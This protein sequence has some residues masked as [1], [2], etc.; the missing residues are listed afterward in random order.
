MRAPVIEAGRP[1]DLLVRGGTVVRAAGGR[2]ARMWRS[3]AAGSPPSTRRIPAMRPPRP[4]DATGLLVLPGVI[5]V[6][7][8]AAI[9][10]D[11]EPDRFFQDTVA[12]AFGGT[13][14]LLAFNNP[15]TGI[16]D[17]ARSDRCAPASR[18]G[19]RR[20]AARCRDRRRAVGGHHRAAGATRSRTL[21]ALVDDGRGVPSSASWSTTSAWTR[22]R[23]RRAAAGRS[24]RPAACSRSTARTGR[25]LDAGIAA[26]LAAGE[27]G[28]RG[29]A[30]SRPP[31][32][33]G[34]R[35][36]AG[37]SRIAR[38]VGAPVY[39]VHVSCR[40]R[41]RGDRAGPP[42]GP[43]RSSARR[44]PHYLALDAS[45]YE[46][47]AE[48][49]DH[50]GHLAAAPL[51]RRPGRAVGRARATAGSDLV[52]TDHVPDRL[53][54]EKRW[55]GPAIHARSRTAPRASRRCC[56]SSYGAGVAERADHASSDW[57]TCCRRPRRGCSAWR[58][59]APSRWA[60]TPTS[61]CS[62]PRRARHPSG[63]PPPH[64][65][66][67]ALRGDGRWPGSSDGSWSAATDVVVDGAFVGARGRGR[68]VARS[69]SV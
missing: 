19:A 62:T 7:T 5:D 48:G 26:Q 24:T 66:L 50:G 57:W 3:A 43:A 6:H 27:D 49:G 45:R 29:H 69:L 33:R 51:R 65:R 20:T 46:L 63:G 10:A 39:L 30:R 60:R 52:A 37:R 47:P 16:S 32:V 31:A 14:T 40:G 18:S 55:T 58:P 4:I 42:T 15:G 11:E 36:R 1:F 13:T 17:R 35:A 22:Q 25:M 41:R 68:Y 61:C 2:R 12:A 56:R 28:P 21:P 54:V 34:E 23:L 67:H 64:Q 59:R 53:A 8:H 38:E 9:P 44:C